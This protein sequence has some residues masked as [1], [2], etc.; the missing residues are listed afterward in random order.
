MNAAPA[1]K[2]VDQ[3]NQESGAGKAEPQDVSAPAG[4]GEEA[5]QLGLDLLGEVAEHH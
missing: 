4:G 2:A 1:L 3:M 5:A